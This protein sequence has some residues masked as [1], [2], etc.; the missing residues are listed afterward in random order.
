MSAIS[1]S[2]SHTH[3]ILELEDDL[4]NIS[5]TAIET[6]RDH[7][8]SKNGKYK[9]TDELPNDVRLKTTSKLH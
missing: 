8:Y 2:Y 4:P 3:N 1:E 9:L 5:F 7:Y 6:E